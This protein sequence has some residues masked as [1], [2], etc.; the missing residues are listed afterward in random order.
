MQETKLKHYCDDNIVL[1][2]REGKVW[3]LSIWTPEF[4]TTEFNPQL[5]H[6][7]AWLNSAAASLWLGF[8]ISTMVFL[9]HVI[10][11]Y[12]TTR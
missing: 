1:I 5:C 6:L 11:S 8:P 3:W 4:N 9:P 12:C 10:Y 2:K 7:A